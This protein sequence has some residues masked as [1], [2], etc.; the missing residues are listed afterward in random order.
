MRDVRVYEFMLEAVTPIAHAEA[1]FGNHSVVART[2]M[3]GADGQWSDVPIVSG[4]TM[5]HRLREASAWTFLDAAGMLGDGALSEA[6]LRLLFNGGMV[7]GN[8]DGS[9]VRLDAYHAMT[10]LVPQLGLLGGCASNRVMP[11]R[12]D[13]DAALLVC[14]ESRA[15]VPPWILNTHGPTDTARAHLQ[16]VQRVRMDATLDPSKARLLGEVASAK[17]KGRARKSEVASADGD[18]MATHQ[19]K[20]STMPR[21]FETVAAGSRFAW[22]VEARCASER[23][24]DAL[25]TML[26]G[27]LAAA[28]VGGKVGTGHGQL[29]LVEARRVTMART[30][31]PERESLDVAAFAGAV[32]RFRAHVVARASKASEWLRDVDA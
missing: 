26:W 31:T 11:G 22:R 20:S 21:T 3:R 17:V 2:K 8:G 6:S 32:D 27:F 9:A 24:V 18:A 7:S 13:V 25:H 19:A 14:D 16:I 5:R 4:D 12:M 10:D 30:L 15:L 23:D 29:R 1:T 28:T